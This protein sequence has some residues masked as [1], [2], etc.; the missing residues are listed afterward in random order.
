MILENSANRPIEL[1]RTVHDGCSWW[2]LSTGD[3]SGV[4]LA[5]KTWDNV[6]YRL[7][8]IDDIDG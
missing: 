6:I 4:G 5:I 3:N 1:G 7:L 2:F 8:V